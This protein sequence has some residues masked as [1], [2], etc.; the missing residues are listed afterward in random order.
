M[1]RKFQPDVIITRFPVT[2]EGG[3]AIIRPAPSWPMK[4]LQQPLIPISLKTSYSM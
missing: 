3:M 2:G 1:I 4:H